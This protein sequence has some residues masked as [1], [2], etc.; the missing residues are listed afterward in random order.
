MSPGLTATGNQ[1]KRRASFGLRRTET[2]EL[3][4]GNVSMKAP[5]QPLAKLGR[6]FR[7]ETAQHF[8]ATLGIHSREF[9]H[10]FLARFHLGV[11]A[12]ADGDRYDRGDCPDGDVS[13]GKH[14]RINKHK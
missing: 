5:H 3:A 10:E 14:D 8:F 6:G 11:A 4:L 12:P 9:A 1:S 13:S 7:I 2:F